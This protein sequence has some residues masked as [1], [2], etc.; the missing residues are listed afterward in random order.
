MP[1]TPEG[2]RWSSPDEPHR[3]PNKE[4]PDDRLNPE[5]ALLAKEVSGGEGEDRDSWPVMS[6][7]SDKPS[8]ESF[9]TEYA[10]QSLGEVRKTQEEIDR[11]SYMKLEDADYA[12]PSVNDTANANSFPVPSHGSVEVVADKVTKADEKPMG[13]KRRSYNERPRFTSKR[14]N[15]KTET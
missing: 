8:E 7:H 12:P 13:D 1:Q 11:T 6:G 10:A 3:Q 14:W 2:N 5:E 4:I 15:P 9:A